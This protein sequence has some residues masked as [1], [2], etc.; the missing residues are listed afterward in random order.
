MFG[1]RVAK[2]RSK[3][4]TTPSQQQN[5]VTT[6]ATRVPGTPYLIIDIHLGHDIL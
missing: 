6:K 1:G 2:N 3:S 5:P 4:T